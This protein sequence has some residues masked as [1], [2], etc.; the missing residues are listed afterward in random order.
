MALINKD[1]QSEI[2]I[3]E[4]FLKSPYFLSIVLFFCIKTVGTFHSPTPKVL[5]LGKLGVTGS[6]SQSGCKHAAELCAFRRSMPWTSQKFPTS[7][8]VNK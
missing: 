4:V 8:D 7:T 1:G 6:F 2:V 5:L 3:A